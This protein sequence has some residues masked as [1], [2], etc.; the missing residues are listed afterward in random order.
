M[1]PVGILPQHDQSTSSGHRR[2][3]PDHRR[4]T[5]QPNEQLFVILDYTAPVLQAVAAMKPFWEPSI[6]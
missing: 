3:A 2:V 6:N 4:A 5:A 1:R